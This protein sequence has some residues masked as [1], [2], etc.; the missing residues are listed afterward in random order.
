M[1]LEIKQQVQFLREAMS[2]AETLNEMSGY[3]Q[4]KIGLEAAMRTASY[5]L[6]VAVE[7]VASENPSREDWWTIEKSH[8]FLKHDLKIPSW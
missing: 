2:L 4:L 1:I 8:K 5:E 3:Y 7:K 6:E